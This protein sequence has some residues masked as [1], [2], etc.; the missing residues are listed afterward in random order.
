MELHARMTH[1]LVETYSCCHLVNYLISGFLR[2]V[3]GDWNESFLAIGS[4]VMVAAIINLTEPLAA[5][6]GRR[7]TREA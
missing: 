4:S 3:T 1:L 5:R 6:Y 7:Q 2:D